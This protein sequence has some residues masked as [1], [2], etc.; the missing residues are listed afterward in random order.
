MRLAPAAATVPYKNPPRLLPRCLAEQGLASSLP[1]AF[2]AQRPPVARRQ[3]IASRDCCCVPCTQRVFL[4]DSCPLIQS[5]LF[6]HVLLQLWRLILLQEADGSFENAEG[7]ALALNA[8][9]EDGS[10]SNSDCPL[11][12]EARW[13][14]RAAAVLALPMS[15]RS[16]VHVYASAA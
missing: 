2:G 8:P 3:E 6:G 5:P 1:G 10:Q 14:C 13:H 9:V 4:R 16:S 15:N 7:L 11:T 12:S